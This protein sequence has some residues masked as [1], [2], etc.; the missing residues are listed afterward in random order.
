[1]KK[2]LSLLL[3]VLLLSSCVSLAL[4]ASAVDYLVS[5]NLTCPE[6][7]PEGAF[8]TA[9]NVGSPAAMKVTE[10]AVL[11]VKEDGAVPA[12]PPFAAG[13]TYQIV[14]TVK[15]ANKNYRFKDTSLKATVNGE[16]CEVQYVDKK[17]ATVTWNVNVPV[18]ATELKPT[19]MARFMSILKLLF[20]LLRGPLRSWLW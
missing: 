12:E 3:A 17:F 10:V 11:Q 1:M 8:P 15:V 14:F 2:A 5:I 4:N 20:E 9:K 7:E 16:A 18:P 13:E 19:P 6:P